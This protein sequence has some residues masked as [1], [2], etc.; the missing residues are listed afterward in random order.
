MTVT[1]KNV[2][3]MSLFSVHDDQICFQKVTFTEYFNVSL[4][5]SAVVLFQTIL[6][7]G[8]WSKKHAMI[9]GWHLTSWVTCVAKA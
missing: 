8:F 5:L 7:E 3:N 6:T 9:V 4:V 2:I 1:C